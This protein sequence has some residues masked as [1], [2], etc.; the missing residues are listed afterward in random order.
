MVLAVEE[1]HADVL[2]RVAG[3]A[4]RAAIASATPFSTAG[5]KPPGITPPLIAFSNSRPAPVSAGEISMWQSANWPRPPVCF[6]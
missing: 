1:A 5:M 4:R 6:L 2:D 3:D